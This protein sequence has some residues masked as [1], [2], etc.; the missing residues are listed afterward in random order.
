MDR[1]AITHKE[2]ELALWCQ[3]KSHGE[4][5]EKVFSTAEVS[6]DYAELREAVFKHDC[7]HL[8]KSFGKLMEI[9]K[10]MQS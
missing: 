3:D 4:K 2:G 8:G 9:F 6:L 5:N 10:G 7:G 1:Y